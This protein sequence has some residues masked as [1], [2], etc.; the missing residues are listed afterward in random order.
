MATYPEKKVKKTFRPNL[1]IKVV[2]QR[3]C[4]KLTLF[5]KNKIKKRLKKSLLKGKCI[6]YLHPLSEI[7]TVI[8]AKAKF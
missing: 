2:K 5:S 1:A 6:V 8:E 4:D 7:T 3:L